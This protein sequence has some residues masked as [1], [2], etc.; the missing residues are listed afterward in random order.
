MRTGR[1]SALTDTGRRRPHNEDTFVC[2]PPLFAVADGV[3]GAQAGEIASRL[4]AA[5]LEERLPDRARRGDARGADPDGQR[6]DLP[7]LARR[8]GRGGDGNGRDRA[9]RRRGCGRHRDRPRRGLPR[10]P[11]AGR[12]VRAA[13][14]RS[15]ARRRARPLRATLDG[16]GRAPSAPLGDHARRRHRTD[17]R[18]R[19]AHRGCQPGGPL[20]DLLRRA[21][22]HRARRADRGADP[23]SRSRPR[24]SGRG[25]RRRGESCRRDRQH[26]RRPV[27]D[28]R[29]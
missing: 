10:L 28:H 8:S 27:R 6:P 12:R 18:C 1:A 13:H 5:A 17:R 25:A 26:H 23:G 29:G 24:C 21:H 9:S 16:G 20:P 15:L 22:G 3:G 7:P 19:D 14:P 11:A 2:D 4:A